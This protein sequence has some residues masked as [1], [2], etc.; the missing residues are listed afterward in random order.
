MVD[1]HQRTHHQGRWRQRGGTL[2]ATRCGATDSTHCR[3]AADHGQTSWRCVGRAAHTRG[4]LARTTRATRTGPDFRI[5]NP[6][7]TLLTYAEF[8]HTARN[9]QQKGGPSARG[10]QKA[11][12]PH[13]RVH[14]SKGVLSQKG[15]PTPR[16]F[17]PVLAYTRPGPIA[18]KPPVHDHPHDPHF[19]SQHPAPPTTR[20]LYRLLCRTPLSFSDLTRP[21]SPAQAHLTP[22]K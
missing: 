18:L 17:F 21:V 7:G 16:S 4:G 9:R 20:G 10:I 13:L 15:A 19:P 1:G 11:R 5:D 12:A 2:A 3:P 6:A 14:R 8:R 22:K